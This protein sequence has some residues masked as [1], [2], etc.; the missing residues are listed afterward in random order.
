MKSQRILILSLFVFYSSFN[1]FSANDI[2]F[3]RIGIEQ[4]LSQLSVNNIYQ[5]ELGSVWFA[6]REGLNKY[7]GNSMEVFRPVPNDSNSLGESLILDV[8][9]DKNGHVFIQTQIG[10]NEYDLQTSA[11]RLIQ[12]KQVSSIAYGIRNLW[13]AE[14]TSLYSYKDGKKEFYCNVTESKTEIRKILQASDQRIFIGT[15]S[16]GVF[17]IDQNKKIR[18]V[19]PDCSQVSDVFEDSRKNIWV[20]TWEKRFI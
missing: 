12:K 11:M 10:V 16:S 9:G 13:M 6:T 8:C 7:N 1:I 4:G 15:L 14:H 3:S 20:A 19:I 18:Q 17:V 2:Y 5:D